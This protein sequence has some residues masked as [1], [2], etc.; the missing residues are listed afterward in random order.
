MSRGAELKDLL[1]RRAVEASDRALDD[2]GGVS[3]EETDELERLARLVK[4][5]GQTEKRP[6]RRR[7]PIAAAL[8]VSY[9]NRYPSVTLPPNYCKLVRE[10]GLR[11]AKA[12]RHKNEYRVLVQDEDAQRFGLEWVNENTGVF[13]P[14]SVVGV[15][16]GCLMDDT[17]LQVIKNYAATAGPALPVYRAVA[18]RNRFKIGFEQIA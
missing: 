18:R 4:I 2:G 1:R 16:V 17:D 12:W 15:T 10:F 5:L 14:G 6:R 11:K 13:P 8:R 7:W 3:A 9:G